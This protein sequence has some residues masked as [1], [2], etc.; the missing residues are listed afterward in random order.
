M[1]NIQYGTRNPIDPQCY[2]LLPPFTVPEMPNL[3][4]ITG[5]WEI[6]LKSLFK[7][8]RRGSKGG[9]IFGGP[10]SRRPLTATWNVATF[11]TFFA[12]P[13]NAYPSGVHPWKKRY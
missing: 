4:N 11:T 6:I 5:A 9:M 7:S 10:T 13:S 3:P 8:T 1:L 2:P 12:Q